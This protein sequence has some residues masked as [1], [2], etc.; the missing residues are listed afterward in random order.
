MSN[1]AGTDWH[2]LAHRTR[3]PLGWTLSNWLPVICIRCH[4]FS[5]SN[6]ILIV[7][8]SNNI[9]IITIS[10]TPD[11]DRVKPRT[12]YT[13]GRTRRVLKGF[14]SRQPRQTK[15][16]QQ[17]ISLFQY[18][19]GP[20]HMFLAL[21]ETDKRYR[22]VIA[23]YLQHSLLVPD[24]RELGGGTSIGVF[25]WLLFGLSWCLV[26]VTLPFSLCVLLKVP[27]WNRTQTLLPSSTT[28]T[29]T[30]IFGQYLGFASFASFSTFLS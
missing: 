23:K 21:S 13:I 14:F 3:L 8:F 19:T 9:Y 25:G 1:L 11:S 24:D 29:T 27:T 28:V 26:A 30:F 22:N 17:E 6:A 7:L 10:R 20:I 18:S 5:S 4:G 15:P 16:K 12:L 2:R